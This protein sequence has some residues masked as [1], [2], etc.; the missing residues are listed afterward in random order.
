MKIFLNDFAI[1]N[2][3]S[4]H[5][6][7]IKIYFLKYKKYGSSLNLEKCAFMV[8]LELFKDF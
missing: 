4:T 8:F 5:L 2:E 7:K 6:E 3:F 1:F